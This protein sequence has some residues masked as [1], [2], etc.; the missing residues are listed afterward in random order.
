MINWV[1][2]Y[3]LNDEASALGS[4]KI[5]WGAT[6]TGGTDRMYLGG[7]ARAQDHPELDRYTVV[8]A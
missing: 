3:A 6:R 5:S 1:L 8:V 4:T 7:H 2:L